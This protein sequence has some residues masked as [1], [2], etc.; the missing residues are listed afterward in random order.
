M[1]PQATITVTAGVDT[2][3]RI[4]A[5]IE[6]EQQNES[7]VTDDQLHKFVQSL[8]ERCRDVV[9]IISVSS[10]KGKAISRTALR[11]AVAFGQDRAANDTELNGVIG[12]IGRR[13]KQFMSAPNPFVARPKSGDSDWMYQIDIE[14]AER[15]Y[16]E[17]KE[18]ADRW[19]AANGEA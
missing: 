6:D 3:R 11:G 17:L 14:L 15:L 12:T 10:L 4:L 9:A 2:I 8:N 7:D 18:Q 19:R 13:W 16:Q 1:L 5:I